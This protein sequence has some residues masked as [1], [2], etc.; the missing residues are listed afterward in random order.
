[1]VSSSPI[2]TRPSRGGEKL[3]EYSPTL[4]RVAWFTLRRKG[5]VTLVWLGAAIGLGL[6]FPQ[7]ESVIREQSVDPIPAGVPS[8]QTLDRMGASFDERGAKT[9][10]FVV[11]ENSAGLSDNTR[12]RYHVL[13]DTLRA[14]DRHVI[15]VRDLLSDPLTA[16]QALSKDKQA[17]Y[18]PVGVAG[19][20]GGP[21]TAEA[22]A[23]VREIAESIF[24]DSGT[25]VRVTGPPATFSDQLAVGESDLVLITVATVLLIAVILLIVYRSVFTALMPLLVVGMSLAVGRGVLS[26]LGE[27]GMPV[28]QFTSMFMTV[29][30]FGAG[31]DYSVF[32]ISRYHEGIRAGYSP[33]V[34]IAHA[35]A[36]IGRVVLASAG[37]V[38][39]ASR[40]HA[41]FVA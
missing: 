39:L 9:T 38:A 36:T 24:R 18:L 25:T 8:F 30:I 1:M 7:L 31:V 4:E 23:A 15:A 35:N 32:L 10:V 34:A 41:N 28:S 13:V 33:D 40:F 37:T 17:W 21:D 19:T 26:G 20:L 6:L 2:R 27:L 14:D 5:I 3:G 11:M 12:D 29:I 22:V 16:S